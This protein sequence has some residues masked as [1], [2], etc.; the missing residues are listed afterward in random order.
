MNTLAVE[1]N[2]IIRNRKSV[3]LDIL[4]KNK[5]KFVSY[6]KFFVCCGPGVCGMRVKSQLEFWKIDELMLG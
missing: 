3:D 6:D 2:R 1:K 4:V 5:D